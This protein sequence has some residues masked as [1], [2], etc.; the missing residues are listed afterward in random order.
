MSFEFVGRYCNSVSLQ[1]VTILLRL[2]YICFMHFYHLHLVK[3]NYFAKVQYVLSV[4]FCE[5]DWSRS[6]AL[7]LVLLFGLL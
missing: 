3:I 5:V 7:Q 2:P 4:D 1:F 6:Q